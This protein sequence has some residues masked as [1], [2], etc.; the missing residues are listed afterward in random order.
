MITVPDNLP[1]WII[2]LS[3]TYLIG[4]IPFGKLVSRRVADI[5]IT[6]RRSGNI[7][8]TNVARE[9]GLGWGLI[10][11]LLD[12][13]KGFLPTYALLTL[14]PHPEWRGAVVGL[15]ALLGHQFSLFL[16]LRGGKGVAT[17]LGVYL[18]VSPLS[19]LM[20]IFAFVVTVYVSG[21]VSL[22]SMIGASLMPLWMLILH[23]SPGIVLCSILM[24]GLICLKH[25]DNV[26]RLMRGNERMWRKTRVRSTAQEGGQAPHRN[27]S[28]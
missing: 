7:G 20:S 26:K 16:R 5:D 27:R 8:A 23:K 11:L 12:V 1:C 13:A 24:A 28:V 17:A 4:S 10:T 18:A 9:L 25:K 6:K 14:A 22:G 21:F 19:C 3:T 2:L 15:S